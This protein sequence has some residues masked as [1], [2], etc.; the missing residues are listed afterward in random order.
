MRP[1]YAE[2]LHPSVYS[3]LALGLLS[4]GARVKEYPHQPDDPPPS[5]PPGYHP[6]A[7]AR[8]RQGGSGTAE[9]GTAEATPAWLA[10]VDK[11][12]AGNRCRY[13]AERHG[14]M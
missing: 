14:R 4:L 13:V 1:S 10:T 8:R 2:A 3:E 7:E 6:E 12:A 9:P 5:C 11:Q